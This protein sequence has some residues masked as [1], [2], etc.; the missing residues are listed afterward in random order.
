MKTLKIR[1]MLLKRYQS[2]PLKTFYIVPIA[3]SL[4]L[5][6]GHQALDLDY[7][8][9]VA[10]IRVTPGNTFT[11]NMVTYADAASKTA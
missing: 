1:S 6:L 5:S 3:L 7:I 10:A 4:T 2:A 11:K 9:N 8:L